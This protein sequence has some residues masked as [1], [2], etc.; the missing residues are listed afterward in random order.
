MKPKE[1]QPS[2]IDEMDLE[3]LINA[4]LA[5]DQEA[6]A[7]LSLIAFSGDTVAQAVINKIDQD[8]LPGQE[9]MPVDGNSSIVW[10]ETAEKH[11]KLSNI[12][13]HRGV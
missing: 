13:L 6:L 1:H 3:G 9:A 12:P 4:A 8:G 11:P 2:N 10:T 5:G 7:R